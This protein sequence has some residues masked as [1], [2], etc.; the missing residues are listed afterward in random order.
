MILLAYAGPSA[1]TLLPLDVAVHNKLLEGYGIEGGGSAGVG[2]NALT[3][4]SLERA[5][6]GE[7][8]N[9]DQLWS[10]GQ[11]TGPALIAAVAFGREPC[12]KFLLLQR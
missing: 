4:A 2:A 3:L 11:C 1:L 9:A 6:E 7:Y 12:V 10:C 8:R 5:D